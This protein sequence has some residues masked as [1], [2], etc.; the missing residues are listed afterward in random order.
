MSH[1]VSQLADLI[2]HW[3]MMGCGVQ[4]VPLNHITTHDAFLAILEMS[5]VL[6]VKGCW[7]AQGGFVIAFR[8]GHCNSQSSNAQWLN[9]QNRTMVM[10]IQ[11]NLGCLCVTFGNVGMLNLVFATMM[12]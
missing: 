6:D 8:E 9:A 11:S 3:P 5:L 12:F 2:V 10:N 1:F 7:L 4:D